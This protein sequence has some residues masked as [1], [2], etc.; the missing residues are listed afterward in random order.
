MVTVLELRPF[1]RT[2]LDTVESWFADRDTAQHLGDREWPSE[3]LRLA[4][5]VVGQTWAGVTTICRQAFLA[6]DDREGAVGLIDIEVYDDGTASY[7]FVVAPRLRRRGW[8]QAILRHTEALSILADVDALIGHVATDNSASIECLRKCGYT[9][10]AEP[11]DQGMLAV[12]KLR[13]SVT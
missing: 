6:V 10:A 8:G 9:V 1:C 3:A 7:A 12:T 5:V 13:R 11:G 2:D 4:S